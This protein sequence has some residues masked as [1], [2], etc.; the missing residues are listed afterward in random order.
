MLLA[1]GEADVGWPAGDLTLD[2]VEGTN[3]V[4]GLAGDLGLGLRPDVMEVPAQMCPAAG[5]TEPGGSI[6]SG[7]IELGIALVA[8]GLENAARVAEVVPD[9]VLLPVGRECVGGARWGGS[10]PGPLIANVSPDPALLDT[11]AQ[12]LLPEVALYEEVRVLIVFK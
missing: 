9:M 8:V 6:G 10:R 3:A 5:L 4:Q 2:V 7:S 12:A 1:D 11:L